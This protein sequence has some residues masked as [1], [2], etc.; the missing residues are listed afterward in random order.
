M[1]IGI[2]AVRLNE[3]GDVQALTA[4]GLKSFK[5]GSFKID[6]RDRTD[7]ALWKDYQDNW[8]GV[9]QGLKGEIPQQLLKITK[10]WTRINLPVSLTN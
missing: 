6:L 4:G 10:N 8:K 9:I 7:L 5:S 3:K 1:A 2:A